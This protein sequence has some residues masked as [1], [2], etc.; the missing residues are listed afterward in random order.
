[1]EVSR[2]QTRRC[3][4]ATARRKRGAVTSLEE[5]Q[6][7]TGFEHSR[8]LCH[9]RVDALLLASQLLEGI[10]CDYR[11]DTFICLRSGDCWLPLDVIAPPLPGTAAGAGD[12]SRRAPG[13]SG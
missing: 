11:I 9:V 3:C 4:F 2:T 1:M 13:C 10:E 12:G 6:S 5:D 7:S 8:H